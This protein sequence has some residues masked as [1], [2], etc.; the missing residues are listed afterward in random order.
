MIDPR[1]ERYIEQDGAY[2]EA[3]D[4]PEAVALETEMHIG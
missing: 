4:T 1:K 2:L 3:L